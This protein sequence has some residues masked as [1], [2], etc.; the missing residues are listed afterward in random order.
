MKNHLEAKKKTI[1]T[2]RRIADMTQFKGAR[3]PCP[4]HQN[5]DMQVNKLKEV[6]Q[7]EA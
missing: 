3:L 7:P 4:A 2:P 1:E 6:K 5:R